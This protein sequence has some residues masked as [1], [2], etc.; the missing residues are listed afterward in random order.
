MA[1]YA[2]AASGE[3]FAITKA[4]L[5]FFERYF[6][7]AYPFDEYNQ[8]FVPEFNMGAMENPGCVTF[9]ESYIF[10]GRASETQLARR[11]E[12]ILHE[13]AHVHGFGDVTPRRGSCDLGLT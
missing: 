12:T 5:D 9:N 3:I 4:G 6:G 2:Q 10:R 11:A 8:L 13:L 7:L 1:E